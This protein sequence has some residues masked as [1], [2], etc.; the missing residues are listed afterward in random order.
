MRKDCK[1]IGGGGEN[2]KRA[3]KVTEGSRTTKLY[4]AETKTKDDC[5]TQKSAMMVE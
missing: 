3:D 4:S 5:M 2:D 1:E